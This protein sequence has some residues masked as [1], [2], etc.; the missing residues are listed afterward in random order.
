MNK[1][2]SGLTTGS[3]Y[4]T[5]GVVV[6]VQEITDAALV[7]WAKDVDIVVI[8]DASHYTPP[9]GSDCAA[10]WKT[11]IET[12]LKGIKVLGLRCLSLFMTC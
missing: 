5:G 6:G 9:Y 10:W 7:T 3:A 2:I 12:N 11:K 4:S 1:D 8:K